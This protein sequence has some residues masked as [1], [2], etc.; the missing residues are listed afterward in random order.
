MLPTAEDVR[1]AGRISTLRDVDFYRIPLLAGQRIAMNCHDTSGQPDRRNQLDPMIALFDPTG[2]RVA[3]NDDSGT[4]SGW[5]SALSYTATTSGN[6]TVAVTDY[7]DFAFNG[8]SGDNDRYGRDVGN[9]LLR[10]TASATTPDLSANS[11]EWDPTLGGLT[12]EYT[13]RGT[14]PAG[15]SLTAQL[16]WASGTTLADRIGDPIVANLSNL[17]ARSGAHAVNVPGSVMRIAPSEATHL[18]VVLDPG[19]RIRESRE[20]NNVRAVRDVSLA[21]ASGVHGQFSAQSRGV[22]LGLLREAGA[23]SAT[24]TELQRTAAEQAH[25]MFDNIVRHGLQSQYELYGNTGDGI[26]RVFEGMTRG[27]TA[28]QI[29]ARRQSIEAAMT[30][31]I[32]RIGPGNVSVHMGDFSVSQAI[33]I[34]PSSFTAASRQRFQT[35]ALAAV[36]DGRLAN[37]LYPPSDPAFHLEI[38]QA[39]P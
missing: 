27:L 36:R 31:Q 33:D 32:E 21:Q 15:T 39:T 35:A 3:M 9:Y 16:F 11:L 14:V 12:L 17:N 29:S 25:T 6:W 8:L 7:G 28:R 34:A 23:A 26:V 5:A 18:L 1:V 24:I 2:R 13:V 22:I 37:F 30:A 19:N 4:G 20:D 38:V 10:I